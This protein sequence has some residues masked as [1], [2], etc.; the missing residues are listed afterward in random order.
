MKSSIQS[1]ENPGIVML[2][3]CLLLNTDHQDMEMLGK[4]HGSAMAN[5]GLYFEAA[6]D[7]S[8]DPW[9]CFAEASKN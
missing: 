1:E 7:Q 4:C 5:P 8:L 3:P 9:E 6:S 2:N